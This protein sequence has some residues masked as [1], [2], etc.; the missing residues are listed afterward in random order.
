MFRFSA[1]PTITS[2]ALPFQLRWERY[3]VTHSET[4]RTIP[5]ADYQR[6]EYRI[7]SDGT[8]TEIVL[9]ASGASC[10]DATAPIEQA[11]GTVTSQERLPEYDQGDEYLSIDETQAL[12]QM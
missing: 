3:A 7:G 9:N 10:I 5:M 11:L 12:N 4:R 1:Q 2:G 8:I 6:I